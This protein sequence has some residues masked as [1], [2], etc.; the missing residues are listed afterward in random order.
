MKLVHQSFAAGLAVCL[1]SLSPGCGS[2]QN[3]TQPPPT[4]N[5]S[6]STTVQTGQGG[7][8]E[9]GNGMRIS[10]FPG[11]VP[12]DPAGDPG[13]LVF[14]IEPSSASGSLPS[15]YAAAG[16]A[17]QLGP[18]GIHFA[19]R[20]R[21]SMPVP[22]D[23]RTY[24]LGRLDPETHKW[25][26]VP[27]GLMD[28]ASPRIA[29]DVL[30]LSTWRPIVVTGSATLD[31][32]AYGAVHIQNVDGNRWISFCI[33]SYQ[34]KYPE[35]DVN[36]SAASAGMEVAEGGHNG[37]AG[38]LLDH[39]DW[40][41]PQG[42]YVFEA[43]RSIFRNPLVGDAP[44]DG[45]VELD[46]V[47]IDQASRFGSPPPLNLV[48]NPSSWLNV[49]HTPEAGPCGGEPDYAFGTG[50]VQVTL[51]WDVAAD[52]DLHVFEPSLEEIYYSHKTSAT[53]GRLDRDRRCDPTDITKPENVFWARGAAAHG[54]YRVTLKY[55]GTCAVGP[56][57]VGYRLRT[58]VDGAA[59]TYSGTLAVGDTAMVAAFSR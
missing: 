30:H 3:T 29:A 5:E 42:R 48:L 44:P 14:S 56:A 36:F 57:S 2:H 10:I 52:L 47:V 49:R 37:G 6:V 9:N 11:T 53:G 58:V 54:T 55:Y 34:L 45:W 46:T 50:D 40:Y 41:L 4:A 32:H 33:K 51:T 13:T 17:C 22:I 21:V 16:P 20:C 38:G 59:R 19:G 25:E 15:G 12:T 1:L 24:A 23:G 28:G 26:V 8:I 27:T 7:V 39:G 18:E 43:T 31:P 35:W